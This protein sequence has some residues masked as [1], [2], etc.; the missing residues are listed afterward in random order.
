MRVPFLDLARENGV[1]ALPLTAA[2][3]RVL[4]SGRVL[5]GP[6][7]EA[8][9]AELAAWFGVAH[10]VGVASGT[11]AVEIALRATEAAEEGPLRVTAFTAVPTINAMEAAGCDPVLV[12]VNAGTRNA[13]G[14][15]LEVSLYG[16]T[17]PVYG[18]EVED[19]AH[20]MG[21]EYDGHKAGTMGDAGAVS[22]YPSKILGACGDGGAIITND[23]IIAA[24]ARGIRH[25]G[26]L[27]QGD[28]TTRGQNSRLSE[29]QAA[30]L[31]VKLPHVDG[32]I[33]RRREIAARY[34]AELA[35]CVTVPTEPTGCKAVYHVYVI[36]HP[37]RD[38][39][40]AALEAKGVGT[41]VHYPKAIHEHTRWRHLGAP[42]QFPVAERLARTVL[43]LPCYP[44]L[45]DA[46][47][48][49]VIAAVKAAA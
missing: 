41:M 28:V 34:S 22:F 27:A 8:F 26:G 40:K 31:R 48:D 23:P 35:G 30:I 14:N 17:G 1:L 12:D 43:S 46:E 33:A 18:C 4:D 11:D 9:E 39:L 6:E 42:G 37:E 3:R 10:A 21:A 29:M 49:A 2:V 19:I 32:W 36:E 15:P 16:L 5:M 47:Q 7:V 24:R 45:T 20:S 44:Y 13:F 38:R 25:Y